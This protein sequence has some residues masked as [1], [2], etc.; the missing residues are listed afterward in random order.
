VDRR[1]V[2]DEE[3]NERGGGVPGREEERRHAELLA[4]QIRAER[5]AERAAEAKRK[6]EEAERERAER[7]AKLTDEEL[8]QELLGISGFGSSKYRRVETNHTTASRGAC[9][10]QLRRG[11]R[12]YMHR[13]G[14]FNRLLDAD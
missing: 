7:L 2:D 9:I 5:A 3:Q 10:K 11:Y 13:K 4:E 6:L 8:M 14:G 1:F 12:Q